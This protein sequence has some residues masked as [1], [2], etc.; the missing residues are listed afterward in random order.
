MAAFPFNKGTVSDSIQRHV[1][2]KIY[3]SHFVFELPPLSDAAWSSICNNSAERDRLEF[4]GDALMSGTVSEELYRI[5]IQG[6]PGFYT[7]ARSALTANS[8]F[9]HLMHRLGHHDMRDKVKPAGDAFETIIAAYRNETSAEA[10]QQWFR[11][12]F[13]QLIHVACA[14]YDSWMNLS[15][16]RSKGSGGSVKQRRL[17]DKAKHRQKAEKRARGLL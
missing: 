3:S 17:L 15:M 9:A 6:S 2:D 4:V 8:T 1:V 16:P 13:T 7:N 10:F 11:D 12:N 5:R 14:A